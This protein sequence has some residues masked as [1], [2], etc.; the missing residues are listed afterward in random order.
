MN[1]RPTTSA[2]TDPP[3]SRSTG[4]ANGRPALGRPASITSMHP[5]TADIV[6]GSQT[7]LT[8]ALYTLQLTRHPENPPW[9]LPVQPVDRVAAPPHPCPAA[10]P[11]AV[12]SPAP[13]DAHPRAARHASE[14]PPT[15]GLPATE[16]H[17]PAP[18]PSTAP[19]PNSPGLPPQWQTSTP[20]ASESESQTSHFPARSRRLPAWCPHQ[21]RH[22]R[23]RIA[24]HRL[25]RAPHRP[26]PA[27]PRLHRRCGRFSLG[28]DL[29]TLQPSS[30]TPALNFSLRPKRN[31]LLHFH[32]NIRP[33]SPTFPRTAPAPT[34][35]LPRPDTSR[36]PL[37]SRPPAS[38][39][40][41]PD[42]HVPPAHTPLPQ[43]VP[44][45]RP[46]HY[47]RP[48]II[49]RR[50][51]ETLSFW[52]YWN[53][54][55]IFNRSVRTTSLHFRDKAVTSPNN[56]APHVPHRPSLQRNRPRGP[57]YPRVLQTLRSNVDHTTPSPSESADRL[58][59]RGSP[60]ACACFTPR[61]LPP[62]PA[63]HGQ[64]ASPQSAVSQCT[65]IHVPSAPAPADPTR[66]LVCKESASIPKKNQ[67]R[68]YRGNGAIRPHPPPALRPIAHLPITSSAF[69]SVNASHHTGFSRS[70]H[71]M[72]II[73][74]AFHL[75]RLRLVP[76]VCLPRASIGFVLEGHPFRSRR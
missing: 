32:H 54:D 62:A 34:A 71:A 13:S 68:E 50:K 3:N 11:A 55:P 45:H 23:S 21:P 33:G 43:S 59:Q 8:L 47:G 35:S 70:A 1:P 58:P 14:S 19:Q 28:P 41:A 16:P 72:D 37:H 52:P 39:H 17:L 42:P 75:P 74:E 36:T 56:K 2:A 69:S 27:R 40:T 61:R 48:L 66:G 20:P 4:L 46:L 6:R 12:P 22:A 60:P 24:T 51:P 5:T 31:Q 63:S 30:H 53:T 15:A 38:P 76:L 65:D 64:Q 9:A 44:A 57:G 73:T 25:S 26:A 18:C 10:A 29:R 7:P 49:R 67:R